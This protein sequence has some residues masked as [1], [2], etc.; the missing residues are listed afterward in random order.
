MDADPT[1]DPDPFGDLLSDEFEG[2]LGVIEEAESAIADDNDRRARV[3]NDEAEPAVEGDS[4]D[5]VVH[6][7]GTRGGRRSRS[8]RCPSTMPTGR[9][10]QQSRRWTTAGLRDDARSGRHLQIEVSSRRELVGR[11]RGTSTIG[12]TS[13]VRR[14]STRYP[15][16][17]PRLRPATAT[18]TCRSGHSFA[19][20]PRHLEPATSVLPTFGSDSGFQSATAG[21]ECLTAGVDELE[22]LARSVQGDEAGPMSTPPPWPRSW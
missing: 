7:V 10:F 12:G 17:L 15:A 9:T 14:G 11:G 5:E 20:D 1:R 6:D 21:H 13:P 4:V 18:P 2:S 16:P 19:E 3:G 22:Q 8:P